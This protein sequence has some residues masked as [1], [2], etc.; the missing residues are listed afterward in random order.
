MRQSEAIEINPGIYTL[1]DYARELQNAITN[2]PAVGK[3]RVRVVVEDGALRI[4]SGTFGARG[5]I[6][7]TSGGD[8]QELLP[9]GLAQATLTPGN[10]VGGT[11]NGE[12][13]EGIGQV[14]R[15]SEE[16]DDVKGLRLFVSLSESQISPTVAEASVIV[17]K[18]VASRINSYLSRIVDPLRGEMKRITDGLRSELGSYDQQLQK[19]N[20][21][22]ARKRI[23]LQ[24]K[25][26]RM[27]SQLSSMRSQ[28]RF[29]QSQLGS[30]SSAGLP[31][32]PG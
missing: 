23:T 15:G 10:D 21:R 12:A 17:T 7:F 6:E 5:G 32:L 1:A 13:A 3:R 28:Q 22:V 24:Q 14:L 25:F 8:D 29:L 19:L 27:E 4:Y 9:P 26:T 31:G 20:E 18:G 30:A 11:I 16:S 2:D